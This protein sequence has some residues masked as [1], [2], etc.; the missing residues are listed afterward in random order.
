M[1]MN[2][3]QTFTLPFFSY[4]AAGFLLWMIAGVIL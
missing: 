4:K 3:I 2:G 1:S